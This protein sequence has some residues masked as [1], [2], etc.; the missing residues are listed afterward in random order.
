MKLSEKIVLL[1][2]QNGLSQEALAEKLGVSRQ[3]VSRWETGTAL[4]DASNLLQLSDLFG[5]T[6]DSLLREEAPL[7]A[8]PANQPGDPLPRF[9]APF[10]LCAGLLGNL[11]LYIVSRFVRVMVPHISRGDGQTLYT[12]R[13]DLTGYSYKY[14]V[15]TYSL[16]LLT[17]L[18]WA[19]AV[20]GLLLTQRKRFP[21]VAARVRTLRKR[22]SAF[23]GKLHARFPRRK[24]STDDSQKSSEPQP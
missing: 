22:L 10:L 7:C 9:L 12:W 24:P 1:R 21:A 14:F 5:V 23:A 18:F 17:A 4:P 2:K 16:E 15:E 13:S 6:A 11:T 3:A 19:L 8:A 20:V